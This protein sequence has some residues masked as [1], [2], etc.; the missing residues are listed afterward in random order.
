MGRGRFALAGALTAALLAALAAVGGVGYAA[1]S[2]A[3]A[4]KVAKRVVTP[5]KGAGTIVVKGISAGGDQYRPGYGFGDRNHNHTGPPGLTGGEGEKT[6]PAQTKSV[7]GGEAKLVT[8]RVKLDE[9][10][11]LWISVLDAK[12][13]RL[14]L[15][16]SKSKVGGK[17]TGPQTKTLHYVVLV[18]RSI[19]LQLR[20]PAN[21]LEK[22]ATYRIRVTAIDPSG[23]KT[24]VFIPFTA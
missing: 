23:N 9:Q 24:T 12:G 6:P 10:A 5:Q 1:S 4:V 3:G 8:T 21:L 20:V 19:P 22:G 15:T 7:D 11:A 2:V 16:Q 18:P 14:L 13:D 17:L